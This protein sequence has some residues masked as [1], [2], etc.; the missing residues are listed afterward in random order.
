MKEDNK[1]KRKICIVISLLLI[2]ALV[3]SACGKKSKDPQTGTIELAGNPT[4]GYEWYAFQNSDLFDITN[5]YT[6]DSTDPNI[7]GAGGTYTF[8]LTPLKAGECEVSFVYQRPWEAIELADTSY[9][10]YITVT[11]DMQ[12]EVTGMQGGAGD[13]A[14]T[15]P[16]IPE[17]TVK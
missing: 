1:M 17:I 12:I 10:F 14:D 7:T 8:T 2:A 13:D 4:T 3:L 5:E 16:Q 6:P 11:S 9:T 15:L